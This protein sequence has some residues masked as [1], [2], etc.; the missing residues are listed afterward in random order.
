MKIAVSAL[1]TMFHMLLSFNASAGELRVFPLWDNFGTTISQ[2]LNL[3]DGDLSL[4]VTAW[5]S[6]YDGLGVISNDTDGNDLDAGDANEYATDPNEDL[7]FVFDRRVNLFDIFV[8]DLSSN[9]DFNVSYVDVLGAGQL[10]LGD[11][12][13]GI[14]GPAFH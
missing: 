1:L 9:D 10:E 8:G 14:K 11:T 6:S 7:L 3:T 2:K 12:E 13:F 4:S 5:T